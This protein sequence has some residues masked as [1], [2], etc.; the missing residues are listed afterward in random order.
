M[1]HIRVRGI[2]ERYHIGLSLSCSFVSLHLFSE[3][4][5]WQLFQPCE[6]LCVTDINGLESGVQ[7]GCFQSCFCDIMGTKEILYWPTTTSFHQLQ[8]DACITH[9]VFSMI[10][11]I[12]R[13]PK[14]PCE[15][16]IWGVFLSFS[17]S[18]P[19]FVSVIAV[20][21]IVLCLNKWSQ[22]FTVCKI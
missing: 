5:N 16:E 6:E 12:D 8:Y 3:V 7:S 14:L 20:V 15:G 17:E 18:G 10:F 1:Q 2:S 13:H 21:T 4:T 11:K 22:H 9:S 19:C